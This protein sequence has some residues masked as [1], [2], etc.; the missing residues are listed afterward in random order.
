MGVPDLFRLR[1]GS[2]CVDEHQGVI[3]CAPRRCD[4][5]SRCSGYI[6]LVNRLTA[7][8]EAELFK[9]EREAWQDEGGEG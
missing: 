6:E 4:G 3:E 2:D 9:R 7:A 1:L 5:C 8:V